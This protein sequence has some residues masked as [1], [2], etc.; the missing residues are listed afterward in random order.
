MGFIRICGATLLMLG[1][2][3]CSAGEHGNAERGLPD[4]GARVGATQE[5]SKE[6]EEALGQVFR[7]CGKC[8]ELVVVPAGS[9]MMGSPDL[10]EA[11]TESESP[12]HRVTIA[13]PFAAGVYEVTFEEWDYC[14]S[15]GGC[16]GYS[17]NDYGFGRGKRPVV[18]VSWDDA[19]Q[20]VSWLSLKTG[21][22][23]RLLSEAE[24]E[25]AAR[26][27]TATPYHTGESISASEANFNGIWV[28]E[29]TRD[30][31]LPVG[32]FPGNAFGLHDVHGNVNEWVQDCWNG[33]YEGAPDDGGA[34]EAGDCSRRILRGCSYGDSPGC[35]RSASRGG[36]PK[37]ERSR[38]WGVRVARALKSA[39]P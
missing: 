38:A 11:R 19:Q 26:A 39:N 34:W 18:G 27:G 2:T 21:H 23:Y 6:W 7:D 17:A 15:E 35:L 10:E 31:P 25:Y 33:N 1:V 28:G 9:F 24:W 16:D 37:A 3:P 5:I 8:P 13:E 12:M 14:V 22:P 36:I 29:P 4:S 32:S 20:Y 30:E